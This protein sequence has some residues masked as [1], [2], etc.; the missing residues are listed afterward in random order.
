MQH[1]KAV[2]NQHGEIIDFEWL[3]TNK[4][5]NDRWGEMRGKR[6][7]T[8]NPAV[9]ETGLFEQFKQVTESGVPL[10]QE[11]FYKYEQFNGW[12]LQTVTKDGS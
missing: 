7:L 9:I 3:M 5:W 10:T 1:F 2:R 8:E 12:F 11:H 4:Q 6:L